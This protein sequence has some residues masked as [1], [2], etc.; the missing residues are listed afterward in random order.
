MKA[1]DDTMRWR[2]SKVCRKGGGKVKTTTTATTAAVAATN[3]LS[4]GLT[5]LKNIDK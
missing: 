1:G 4:K 2:G 3:S 5:L